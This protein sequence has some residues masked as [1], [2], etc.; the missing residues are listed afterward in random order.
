MDTDKEPTTTKPEPDD[1]D[2]TVDLDLDA[3]DAEGVVGG[4]GLFIP[5]RGPSGP[6]G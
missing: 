2:L 3:D 5:P 4:N 1:V 6:G